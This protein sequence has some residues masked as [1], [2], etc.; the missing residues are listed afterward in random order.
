MRFA[1]D[2]FG[3]LAQQTATGGNFIDTSALAQ[4]YGDQ[5]GLF[6]KIAGRAKTFSEVVTGNL[7]GAGALGGKDITN[8]WAM[9]AIEA[10]GSKLPLVGA[11]WLGINAGAVGDGTLDAA[12][13]KGL[14]R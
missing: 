11:A 4:R 10:G 6:G 3:N 1:G 5:A 13:R 9:H 7:P 8:Q 14:I 12:R 2:A